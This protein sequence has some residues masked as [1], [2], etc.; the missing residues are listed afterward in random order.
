LCTPRNS[1]SH[2]SSGVVTPGASKE[3]PASQRSSS[4]LPTFQARPWY[5]WAVFAVA[6][7]AFVFGMMSVSLGLV[8][9]DLMRD[10]TIEAQQ[11]G[12]LIAVYSYTYALMQIPGGLLADRVGPRRVMP[13]FLVLG[14][15]GTFVFS[16]APSFG[17]ALAARVLTALGLSVLYVNQVKV[18]RGWFRPEEFATA[19]GI[20]SSISTVGSLL[21]SPLLAVSVT[22]FGWRT[23]FAAS[24]VINLV[25]AAICWIVIRDRDPA[26]IQDT[27]EAETEA[28]LSLGQALKTCLWNRQFMLLFL[29]ALLSYGGL[30]G[31]QQTWGLPFLMQS[32]GLTRVQ[33]AWLVSGTWGI[34]LLAAPVWGSLSDKRLRARKPVMLLGLV[35]CAL[36][37][38]LL[39]GLAHKMSIPQVTVVLGLQGVFSS[40]LLL[41]YTMVNESVPASVSAVAAAGLNM[42]PYIGSGI[43]QALSGF[44]LSSPTSY[45]TDGTPIYAVAAYQTLLIPSAIAGLS[46]ILLG[47]I[48]KETMRQK[49]QGSP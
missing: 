22:S 31:F 49:N 18:L 38:A 16:Q 14:G 13:A 48:V 42:G 43:Y 24:G 5:R 4:K 29:V 34:S 1:L 23:T 2:G 41:P 28:T 10:L 12:L 20:G 19:M 45:A 35:G 47:L 33:A 17:L 37:V 46:A 36:P 3:L 44:M 21:L 30:M 39:A 32:Y 7:L 40:A 8:V 25:M 11:I 9:S 26:L 15:L 27:D 6:N